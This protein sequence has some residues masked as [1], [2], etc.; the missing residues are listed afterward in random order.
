[1][2]TCL[3]FLPGD[4]Y[5]TLYWGTA[6]F[7]RNLQ[8][9]V[10]GNWYQYYYQLTASGSVSGTASGNGNANGVSFWVRPLIQPW[11]LVGSL[12]NY[13]AV[14]AAYPTATYELGLPHNG[15]VQRA[16]ANNW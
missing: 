10:D 5:N 7:T 8:G 4:T 16:Y 12:A 6:V 1:V 13:S 15:D 3:T 2:T 14:R 11:V 9:Q